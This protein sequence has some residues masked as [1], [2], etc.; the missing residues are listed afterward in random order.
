MKKQVFYIFSLLALCS[1]FAF[2]QL[3]TINYLDE[4][5]LSDVRLYQNSGG[6]KLQVLKDS[7]LQENEP[8]LGALLKFNSPIYFKENGP[9][10]VSSA[11]FR[12]TTA[13]QTA[14][15]WNGINI[16]S[17]FTGQTDFNTLLTSGYDRIVVRSGGGSVL[18][19]SGAIGGSVHLNNELNFGRG[20]KNELQLQAGSFSSFFGN[21][22]TEYS[23]EKTSA[24]FGL[25][26]T[27][28]DNDFK[29]LGTKIRN[30][31]G[32]YKNT[33]L[34]A[35]VAFVLNQRNLLKFYT[36]YF[37]GERGFSG[38][39]SAPSKSKYEDVN[40]RNLLEWESYFGSFTSHLNLAY[41]DE[42][43]R[44]FENRENKEHSFGRAKTG[45]LKYDLQY[46]F[47]NKVSLSGIADLQRVTG[48]GS[49]I[50]EA[51]RTTGSAGIVFL[52]E[53]SKFFYELSLRQEFS[54]NY[55]SPLLFA[56]NSGYRISESYDLKFNFSRNYRIPTFND[57]F[58]YSGGNVDLEPEKSLQAELG[59][60]LHLGGFN[61]T[62][63]GY[64]IKIDNLLRWVPQ[65]NGLWVPENTKSVRNYGLE[66]LAN[67]QQKVGSG[68]LKFTG[69]YAYTRS[70]DLE[71]E[72]ELIYVPRHKA[73]ASIAYGLKRFWTFYQF[74][75]NGSVY[76]SSDNAYELDAYA[77]SNLGLEY[78]FLNNDRGSI[79]FEI[80]N[81][82]NENYQ[83]MPSRPMP[84]RAYSTS[85][86]F[87][88]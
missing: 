22:K 65:S 7:T 51:E 14:V 77:V 10:M 50:G 16:N 83:S 6:N 72:K 85:L 58:W 81:L 1:N 41:L 78:D 4:V 15:V 48:E 80:R 2:G 57:L 54:E 73:T 36:S 40:S 75:Y 34:N 68:Y 47:S 19:G 66:A 23:S 5:V 8:S 44:F 53:L 42:T 30:E 12:G 79:G 82:W 27:S 71:L 21:Y 26:R 63:T 35:A 43:Y 86:T 20:F 64:V 45:I 46:Q 69:T 76:T 18:Y 24:Q 13:S 74:L 38:T 28:S 9:G 25:S 39:L 37:D 17:Q 55:D 88:F 70:R 11:A 49:N 62:L 67:W 84:G 3:D 60:E 59:Q 29:Y 32:D 52:H 87:K 31:N 61:F 56:L 33:G